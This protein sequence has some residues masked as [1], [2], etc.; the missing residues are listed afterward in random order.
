MELGL[1]N[2]KYERL[3]KSFMTTRVGMSLDNGEHQ[4]SLHSIAL[5][6]CERG[7]TIVNRRRVAFQEVLERRNLH[8]ELN[9]SAIG[10]LQ[11]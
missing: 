10:K 8:V 6:F 1:I 9:G 5:L 2:E 7:H 4:R 11:L 3:S